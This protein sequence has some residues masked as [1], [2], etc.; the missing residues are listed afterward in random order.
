MPFLTVGELTIS[1]TGFW[2]QMND[3]E[4]LAADDIQGWALEVSDRVRACATESTRIERLRSNF[5]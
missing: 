1:L 2:L 4:T 3:D 5:R